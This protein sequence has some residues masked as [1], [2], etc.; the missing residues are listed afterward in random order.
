MS[1]VLKTTCSTLVEEEKDPSRQKKQPPKGL[2]SGLSRTFSSSDPWLCL[3]E[4]VEKMQHSW[5]GGDSKFSRRTRCV[6]VTLG[7]PVRA[8]GAVVRGQETGNDLDVS[9]MGIGEEARKG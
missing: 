9:G 8:E 3:R 1:Q 2:G 4:L 7:E 6:W 5:D